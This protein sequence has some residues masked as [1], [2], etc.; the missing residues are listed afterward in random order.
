MTA[1][2]GGSA[3][4]LAGQVRSLKLVQPVLVREFRTESTR[5]LLALKACAGTLP[6]A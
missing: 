3:R 2:R 1:G 4:L 5:T 6:E